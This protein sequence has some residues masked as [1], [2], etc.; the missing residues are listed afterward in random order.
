MR[1]KYYIDGVIAL[2]VIIGVIFFYRSISRPHQ[3]PTKKYSDHPQFVLFSFDGSKSN[4]IMTKTRN[5][6]Q[7]MKAQGKPIH[8]TYFVNASYFLTREEGQSYQGPG[9]A[10][11]KTNIGFA[12]SKKDIAKRIEGFNLAVDEGHEIGSH[13]VGHFDGKNWSKEDWEKEFESFNAIL[14]PLGLKQKEIIGFRAPYLSVNPALFKALGEM[15]FRYDTS[16]VSKKDEWPIKDKNGV[17]HIPLGM[18]KLEYSRQE[19]ISMDYSLWMAQSKVEERAKKGTELWNT[20]HKELVDGY[21][22]YFKSHYDGKRSPVV[23]GDHFGEWNDDVYWEA[24]KAFATQVCG[25]PD[26]Y[27]STYKEFVDYLDSVS[28]ITASS[29]GSSSI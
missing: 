8:F 1:R 19:T 28:L 14:A 18:M 3:A 26:V 9:E 27:C 15:H 23:V 11:G 17:W 29:S 16:D 2:F 10:T 21:M 12:E 20:Y 24:L 6:A 25:L 4:D 7:E 22:H 13:T 5:F